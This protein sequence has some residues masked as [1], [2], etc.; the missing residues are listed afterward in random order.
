MLKKNQ[1]LSSL[2]LCPMSEDLEGGDPP[3]LPP[4][5]C[6][7]LGLVSFPAYSSPWQISCGSGIFHILGSLA[8]PKLHFHIFTQWPLMEKIP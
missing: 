2:V 7:S 5:T 1:T 6:V 3:T 4:V 8:Q